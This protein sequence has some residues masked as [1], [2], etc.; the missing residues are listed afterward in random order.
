MRT[1]PTNITDNYLKTNKSARILVRVPNVERDGAV[2]SF[3]TTI[4]NSGVVTRTIKPFG[5][6]EQVSSLNISNLELGEDVRFC[7][8]STITRT[9]Q[10]AL[11]G[12]GRLLN[13]G[14]PWDGY[15]DVRNDAACSS[16][17]TPTITVGQDYEPGSTTYTNIRGF[18][19]ATIPSDLTSCEEATIWMQG[20]GDSSDTDFELVCV[21]GTWLS[22][23]TGIVG[24]TAIFN[25]FTGWAASGAYSVTALNETFNT[26]TDYLA[27]DDTL[28]DNERYNLLRFNA[29]GLTAVEDAAGST[30]KIMILSS[31]DIANTAPTGDEFVQFTASNVE[32][33]LRYNTTYLKN[34]EARVYLYYDPDGTFDDSYTYADALEVY[35]GVIDN[36]KLNN[37]TLD[38]ELKKND[39]KN[40][41]VIPKE[42]LTEE[43]YSEIDKSLIGKPKPIIY[44]DFMITRQHK[45]GIAYCVNQNDANVIYGYRDYVKAYI[46]EQSSTSWINALICGHA[47]KDIEP[48]VV[49]HESGLGVFVLL[50]GDAA[51]VG[52][53]DNKLI[54]VTKG[55]DA[56]KFPYRSTSYL[57]NE[58]VPNRYTEIQPMIAYV[59]RHYTTGGDSA[60]NP[61]NAI[62]TDPTNYA[63][64]N[65]NDTEIY[66]I[67]KYDYPAYGITNRYD[68]QLFRFY[69]ESA[70]WVDP[71]YVAFIAHRTDAQG[72]T[73]EGS[74][75][76]GITGG[77][78]WYN[79]YIASAYIPANDKVAYDFRFGLI[80]N[81]LTNPKLLY[82]FALFVGYKKRIER[83]VFI[84][85]QGRPDD[86][87]GT[88]TGTPA[89]LIENPSH[90]IESLARDEIG[91]A[92]S[93][94]DTTGLDT[95]ATTL[96]DWDFAF[97]MLEQKKINDILDRIGEQCKTGI[98]WDVTNQITGTVWDDS[99]SFPHS[100]TNI[101]GD[102]DIFQESYAAAVDANGDEIMTRNP[103]IDDTFTLDQV[104]A[105]KVKN[106]FVLK[107]KKNYASGEY[108]E[109][110]TM[111]NGEG[112]AGSV[113]H[114][115]VAG[116]ETNMEDS[117][118]RDGL[119]TLCSDSYTDN[120]SITNTLVY[121]A[122]FIR[123]RATAVKLF[124]HLIEVYTPRKYKVEFDTGEN[125]LWV[126]FGDMIN[127]RQDRV[128]DTFGT[129][130]A[131]RKKWSVYGHKHN[132]R[133]GRI[134][135]KAIEA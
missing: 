123:E 23:G 56:T 80:E 29:A 81:A 101:P 50:T 85:V 2:L 35:R 38:V 26:A 39:L 107:F 34:Q 45:T 131:D 73:Y 27:D 15:T 134:T 118:T 42:V 82:N 62:D 71:F 77:N 135:I 36:H 102:L 58:G 90:V 125:A 78:D 76:A 70:G 75:G 99:T 133:T 79:L 40:D 115:L 127:I 12:A 121:E 63:Q 65:T 31:L 52:G 110:L 22:L 92:T 60:D 14:N 67:N 43:E 1:L 24:D 66:Y 112:T 91:F 128:Y 25:D 57:D 20:A 3:S 16:F 111:D 132:Q 64:F 55:A 9:D 19:Q 61:E 106:S 41:M 104:G 98:Y 103:I 117:Q 37:R 53:S 49:I 84:S 13:A 124:Q 44:G 32:L 116:D 21:L 46:Y 59:P 97:Q 5:G 93:E 89:A 28:P 119:K 95:M 4:K 94:I 83:E 96:T 74:Y 114:N 100:A 113:S 54:S 86:G 18:C 120:R 129:P 109:V 122:E 17:A 48:F 30:L 72:W 51:A 8:E 87:S 10:G 33:R 105:E 130:T 69:V 7:D 108:E 126:E 6:L 68:E 47:L 11:R 88:I